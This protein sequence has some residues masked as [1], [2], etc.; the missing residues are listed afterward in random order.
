MKYYQKNLHKKFFLDIA[1]GASIKVDIKPRLVVFGFDEDQKKGSI[2]SPHKEKLVKS[3]DGKYL[4]KGDP[5]NFIN[6]IAKSKK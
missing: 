5:K 4:D 2:W 6:G 3:L 1:E